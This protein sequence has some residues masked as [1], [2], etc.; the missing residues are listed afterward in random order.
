MLDTQA[1]FSPFQH[2]IEKT[3]AQALKLTHSEMEKSFPK[4][5]SFFLFLC[6][7]FLALDFIEK[8][9]IK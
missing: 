3:C 7:I 5:L 9:T 2:N 4:T 1:V 6:D 8:T